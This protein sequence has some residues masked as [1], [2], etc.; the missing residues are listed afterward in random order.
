MKWVFGILCLFFAAFSFGVR[1]HPGNAALLIH[2]GNFE[3]Y[4]ELEFFSGRKLAGRLI[5]ES[6]DAVEITIGAGTVV[7]KKDEIKSRRWVDSEA[8]KSGKYDDIILRET[9]P[10][11]AL[12]SVRYEDSFFYAAEKRLA[13][14]FSRAAVKIRKESAARNP[15]NA[16]HPGRAAAPHGG[17]EL[18]ENPE[19]NAAV[20]P[21]TE[22]RDFSS[23][24]NQE[25]DY[26]ALIKAGL[27]QL[28][29]SAN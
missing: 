25:Q 24:N 9:H 12:I 15:L 11:R 2:R 4:Y 3:N 13:G 7:L 17:V 1:V 6:A 22:G 27:E 23:E 26:S 20:M 18:A 19:M 16:P 14:L 29:K 8:V 5:S 10:D 21:S 28:R